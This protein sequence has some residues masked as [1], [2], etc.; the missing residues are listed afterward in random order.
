MPQVAA[1]VTNQG[2]LRTAPDDKTKQ[3]MEK[4]IAKN[5]KTRADLLE[6]LQGYADQYSQ[7]EWGTLF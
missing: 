1:L 6:K 5:I 7:T 2:N 4:L 3:L